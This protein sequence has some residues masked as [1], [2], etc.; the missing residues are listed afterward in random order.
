MSPSQQLGLALGLNGLVDR[1]IEFAG[2]WVRIRARAAHELHKPLSVAASLHPYLPDGLV[3]CELAVHDPG[4]LVTV[5]GPIDALNQWSAAEG[6]EK[7]T[8]FMEVLSS[9]SVNGRTAASADHVRKWAAIRAAQVLQQSSDDPGEVLTS[10]ERM[11]HRLG[12]SQLARSLASLRRLTRARARGR[13][14]IPRD[15][16]GP[17][18]VVAWRDLDLEA[19]TQDPRK[20]VDSSEASPAE[21]GR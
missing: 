15:R 8:R 19:L 7:E 6:I 16:K 12:D 3:S 13:P 21:D 11:A 2:D 20:F 9:W 10:L 18:R 14:G 5:C 1:H 4:M 17:S